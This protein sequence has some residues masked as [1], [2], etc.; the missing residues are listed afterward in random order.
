VNQP[1]TSRPTEAA[2]SQRAWWTSRWVLAVVL[3]VI[4]VIFVVENREPAAIRLL[5]PLVV[6]PQWAALTVSVLLGLAIGFLLR[7]RR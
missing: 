7:R 2:S 1:R 6:M 4:A 5:I 3:A